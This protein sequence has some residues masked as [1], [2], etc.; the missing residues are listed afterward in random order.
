MIVDQAGYREFSYNKEG[1]MVEGV[2]EL[3]KIQIVVSKVLN[4]TY[5][6]ISEGS[7]YV[8]F[9]NYMKRIVNM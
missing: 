1:K 6:A 7:Q 9:R 2:E 3:P 5:L 4:E 8:Y